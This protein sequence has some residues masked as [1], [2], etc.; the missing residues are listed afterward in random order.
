MGNTP[1][2]ILVTG[3]TG[4]VGG[5]L[6][7][8]LEKSGHVIRCLARHRDRLVER[9]A[10]HV[11]VVEGDVTKPETLE[12]A[13][14]G[15]D[16]AFYLI[17]S[18]GA[19]G[20]FES[21]ELAGARNFGAAAKQAGVRRIIYLGGLSDPERTESAH[22]RSRHAVG[23]ALRESGVPTIEFRASIIIGAGSLSFEL[24]RSLVRRLPIMVVPRWV[25][26][27]AQPIAIDDVL[28][29][30]VQ[31]IELPVEGS[32]SYEIGGQERVSYLDLMKQYGDVVGLHRIYI[33]V[34]F[35][36]P[37]LSSLWLNLVTPL[38]AKVGRKLIDSI[39]VASV[40]RDER[41][42][43][44]FTVTPANVTDAIRRALEE[45]DRA[46]V[47]THWSDA[48]SHAPRKPAYGGQRFGSRIVDARVITVRAAPEVAF[49]AIERIGARNG[50]YYADWLWTI[51]G[52]LDRLIGGVGMQRGRRD[53][54]R[55]RTG[56]VVDCWRVES[57]ERPR[58]LL[59]RAEMKV[60]GRAWLQFEVEPRNG[61]TAI[62]QTAIYDPHGISGILYW[63]SLYPIHEFVFRGMLRGIARA[64]DGEAAPSRALKVAPDP[65]SLPPLN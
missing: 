45:E 48:L 44:D 31:A 61:Q 5:R 56:D 22:M 64:V 43:H 28:D 4:Y 36:T 12:A 9:V 25:R 42:L 15:V 30:L 53:P 65:R 6:V 51:R 60:F 50:W 27:N 55:L 10:R 63:Y 57:I 46:F 13:L 16:T 21:M 35:L 29:Y 33:N 3:A 49:A 32:V 58:K 34:P 59:L 2:T 62:L 1:R 39:R 26:V 7:R 14:D 20:D 18:L 40:V 11:E 8:R 23:A 47:E 37:R 38:F 54:D 19:G 41:A 17:H 52:L 24:I